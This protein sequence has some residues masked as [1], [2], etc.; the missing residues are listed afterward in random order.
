MQNQNF[1]IGHLKNL[2]NF[3]SNKTTHNMFFSKKIHPKKHMNV[4]SNHFHGFGVTN[5]SLQWTCEAILLED[6]T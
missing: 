1:N 5:P 3:P 2:R 4:P 6:A